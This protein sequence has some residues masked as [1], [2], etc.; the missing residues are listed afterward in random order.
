MYYKTL[1]AC[2]I[3]EPLLFVVIA[4]IHCVIYVIYCCHYCCT[5]VSCVHGWQHGRFGQK[6]GQNRLL[7]LAELSQHVAIPR[8]RGNQYTESYQK[9]EYRETLESGIQWV[10]RCLA[11]FLWIVGERI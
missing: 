1:S 9:K 11:M 6:K 3:W 10:M 5:F 2:V 4:A 8:E 7:L